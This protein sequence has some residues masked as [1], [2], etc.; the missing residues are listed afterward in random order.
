MRLSPNRFKK[1]IVGLILILLVVSVFSCQLD[2]EIAKKL[3][4]R[5][6]TRSS[7]RKKPPR[8]DLVPAPLDGIK[9]DSNRS[10]KQA[11]GVMV[12][13]LKSVRPQSGISQAAMVV[14][15]LTEGGITRFMLVFHEKG[16]EKIG[17]VRSARSHFVKLAKGLNALYAHVGGSKFALED[18]KTYGIDDL[19]QFAYESAFK[20]VSGLE[21][22]HN[23]FT[24][25]ASLREAKDEKKLPPP[26]FSFKRDLPK[27]DRPT[28]QQ[29]FIDFSL[30]AYE[31]V[32]DYKPSA[33]S[34]LR[35]NGGRPH[36]D[37]VTDRQLEAKNILIMAAPTRQIPGTSLLDVTVIGSGALKVIR[38]GTEINGT[39]SKAGVDAPLKIMDNQGR[40]IPLNPGQVWLEIVPSMDRVKIAGPTPKG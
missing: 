25:T 3:G 32:W 36:M 40:V 12:E 33:N 37:A 2:R 13:N 19:N 26:A 18:I 15:G 17:P 31:V 10:K 27:K 1:I 8:L 24:G 21:A 11:I 9:I 35:T 22:P 20:R 7:D 5:P 29:V 28:E 23:V 4:P 16:A 34:Y 6:K 30:P 39:W 14:E 38:D